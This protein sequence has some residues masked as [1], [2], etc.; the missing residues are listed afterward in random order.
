MRRLFFLLLMLLGSAATVSAQIPMRSGAL[1]VS[2]LYRTPAGEI[3]YEYN[4]IHSGQKADLYSL[5][6]LDVS[7]PKDA[8]RPVMLGYEGDFL[9]DALATQFDNVDVG[10]APLHV[11]TPKGW[12]ANVTR[13]GAVSWGA[14]YYAPDQGRGLVVG[15]KMGGLA[16][17]SPALPSFRKFLV[18]PFRP[19]RDEA[20]PDLAKVDSTWIYLEGYVL[21]P[22]RM[23]AQADASYLMEQVEGACWLGM[24]ER[25]DLYRVVAADIKKAEDAVDDRIYSAHV[26]R[27][28]AMIQKDP[29]LKKH[30]KLVLNSTAQVLRQIP[31]SARRSRRPAP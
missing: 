17:R 5:V 12:S 31:P 25:C 13:W 11:T 7:T 16:L 24:F 18:V 23:P 14:D 28:L 3:A 6:Y 2:R 22:G 1:S 29:T 21:G 26:G 19:L 20:S 15:K 10:H 9:F 30:G 4:L 27:L 8:K